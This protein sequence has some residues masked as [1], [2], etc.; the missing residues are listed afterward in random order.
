MTRGEDIGMSLKLTTLSQEWCRGKS[1][2]R[3]SDGARNY[4]L[5]VASRSE[6]QP[7]YGEFASTKDI[8]LT[9]FPVYFAK[10]YL[11]FLGSHRFVTH[12]GIYCISAAVTRVAALWSDVVRA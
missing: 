6:L 7:A 11:K 1:K 9:H 4:K 12:F 8:L 2:P 5:H 10:F 3:A